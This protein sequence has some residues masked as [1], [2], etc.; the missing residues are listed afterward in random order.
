MKKEVKDETHSSWPLAF[1]FYLFFSPLFLLQS[2]PTSLSLLSL[3]DQNQKLVSKGKR[4]QEGLQQDIIAVRRQ[5]RPIIPALHQ[6]SISSLLPPPPL[7]CSSP[8]LLLPRLPFFRSSSVDLFL[9][10]LFPFLPRSLLLQFLRQKGLG[11]SVGQVASTPGP[12]AV[13]KIRPD[14]VGGRYSE[15]SLTTFSLLPHNHLPLLSLPLLSLPLLL[16]LLS[17]PLLLLPLLLTRSQWRYQRQLRQV[18]L[19]WQVNLL[20]LLVQQHSS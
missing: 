17:L 20:H 1:H 8:P 6:V 12:E 13:R 18:S 5:I 16:S 4:E 11:G 2:P 19:S 15:A 7:S 14:A 9:S 10:Q 3:P